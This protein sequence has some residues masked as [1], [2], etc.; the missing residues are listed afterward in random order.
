MQVS[1][2]R[3]GK[4]GARNKNITRET[5]RNKIRQLCIRLKMRGRGIPESKSHRDSRIYN[6]RG[7][8]TYFR[9][10]LECRAQSFISA[11]FTLN[12][13]ILLIVLRLLFLLWRLENVY[14]NIALSTGSL[15]KLITHRSSLQ[16][17]NNKGIK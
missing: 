14:C 16:L 4:S 6:S 10:S 9:L 7:Q 3:L 2:A 12:F 13:S 11:F 15:A 8:L 1:T 17:I 5:K